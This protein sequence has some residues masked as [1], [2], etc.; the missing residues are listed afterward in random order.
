MDRRTLHI[1]K[2]VINQHT[3][4]ITHIKDVLTIS[5]GLYRIED[6]EKN[7]M[8]K[9]SNSYFN[10]I[11]KLHLRSEEYLDLVGYE[12]YGPRYLRYPQKLRIKYITRKIRIKLNKL[13]FKA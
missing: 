13:I 10:D 5:Q 8:I 6:K 9:I 2:E 11:W 4:C 3:N 12:L 1:D 7:Q